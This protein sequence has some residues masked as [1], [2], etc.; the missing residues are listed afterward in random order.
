MT[1]APSNGTVH[2][3]VAILG[4]RWFAIDSAPPELVELY[5][6]TNT[7][8]VK[9]PAP[10]ANSLGAGPDGKLY[11]ASQLVYRL[12]P[13][14]GMVET[15]GSLPAGY[16]SSGDIAFFGGTMYVSTDGPCGGALVTFD[17]GTGTSTVL[18]GDGLGCVYGLAV[19]GGTMF[20]VNCDGKVGTFDPTSGIAHVLSTPA[21]SV[22]GADALP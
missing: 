10:S 5:P 20:I 17:P 1:I 13:D 19:T 14:N 15:L 22:Y 18:G 3:D 12:D 9:F 11:A 7:V 21:V 8:K 16:K 2:F 6:M 4:G